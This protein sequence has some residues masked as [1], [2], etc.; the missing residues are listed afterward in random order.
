MTLETSTLIKMVNNSKINNKKTC[1]KKLKMAFKSLNIWS[2]FIDKNILILILYIIIIFDVILLFILRLSSR[3][4]Y[5]R[6]L[7]T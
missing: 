2:S 1:Y 6:R 3:K 4:V 7:F 5:G